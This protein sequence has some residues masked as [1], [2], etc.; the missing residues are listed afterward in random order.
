[1]RQSQ[2]FCSDWYL[3]I[4]TSAVLILHY[5]RAQ[6]LVPV[7]SKVLFFVFFFL[8]AASC[9]CF[10][11][12]DLSSPLARLLF[13]LQ[14][15]GIFAGLREGEQSD[16]GCAHWELIKKTNNKKS[17]TD[18]SQVKQARNRGLWDRLAGTYRWVAWK[19]TGSEDLCL[20]SSSQSFNFLSKNRWEGTDWQI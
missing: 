14:L 11:V 17:K 12:M 2:K 1:M 15:P 19:I 6:K 8:T 9:V 16:T 18:S 13:V 5:H 20:P 3:D 7:H 4:W 10:P